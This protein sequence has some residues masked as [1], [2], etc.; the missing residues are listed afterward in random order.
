[1]QRSQN[2]DCH[3]KI[4]KNSLFVKAEKLC[5]VEVQCFT[6]VSCPLS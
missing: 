6:T 1:M 4:T 5:T 2:L 3:L